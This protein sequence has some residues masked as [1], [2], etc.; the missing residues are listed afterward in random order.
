MARAVFLM[1]SVIVF[2]FPVTADMPFLR[3]EPAK[4]HPSR[5]HFDHHPYASHTFAVDD[6]YIG[7]K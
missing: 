4:H 1:Y 3:L 2:L 6:R 5:I 7:Q